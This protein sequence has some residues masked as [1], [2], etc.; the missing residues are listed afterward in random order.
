VVA[1]VRHPVSTFVRYA[2]PTV[3]LLLVLV[4]SV[5]AAAAAWSAADVVLAGPSDPLRVF[6]SVI[7]FVGIWL[8]GLLLAS[9]ACAW[10]A[11]VWT[12]AEVLGEGTFGGSS[13]RRPG[14]WHSTPSS[15]KV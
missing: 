3:A 4:P 15:A 12:T 14:H 1:C 6:A 7:L 11:A 13:D 8:V 5:V 10:R 2:A 9:V